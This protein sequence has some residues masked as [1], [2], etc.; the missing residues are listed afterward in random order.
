MPFEL[1]YICKVLDFGV[2]DQPLEDR[3]NY[4]IPVGTKYIN[5]QYLELVKENKK[6]V[7]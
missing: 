1:F 2:A 3:F 5:G 4:V 6:K 7:F